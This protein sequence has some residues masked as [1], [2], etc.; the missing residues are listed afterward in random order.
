MIPTTATQ[1]GETTNITFSG[2]GVPLHGM[3]CTSGASTAIWIPPHTC[4]LPLSHC[5]YP[6][7]FFVSHFTT[8]PLGHVRLPTST[9]RTHRSARLPA[10]LCISSPCSPAD[11]THTISGIS[12]IYSSRHTTWARVAQPAPGPVITPFPHLRLLPCSLLTSVHGYRCYVS[13]A[14]T[15]LRFGHNT[16]AAA[17]RVTPDLA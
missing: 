10:G 11:F 16:D 12:S 7:L 8:P 3:A 17:R 5:D 15:T 13:Y 2:L 9:Y 6:Y 4:A 14:P 1:V